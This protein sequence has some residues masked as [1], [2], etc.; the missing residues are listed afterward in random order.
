MA[1]GELEGK[2]AFVSGSGRNIGKAIALELASMGANLVLNVRSNVDEADAVAD[3]VRSRGVEAVTIVGDI[4]AP[5][6]VDEVIGRAGERFG[7]LDILVI[8]AA[9][10]PCQ[11]F[12]DTTEED[13]HRV[14]DVQLH[15]AFRLAKAATPW[16]IE[17]GWGRIIHVTGPD[18]FI[19]LPN[20]AHNVVAKAGLRGLTKSLAIELGRHGITVNDV[21]PGAIDTERSHL[22]H[23][24]ITSGGWDET[25]DGKH[26]IVD[27]IPVGRLGLPE[28]L[29]YACGFLASPRASFVTGTVVCCFGGHW[30][31]A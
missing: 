1:A 29:A 10:R 24:Q 19:G 5:S 26:Q 8:N 4:A 21:A 23:P 6:T 13:W 17:H 3:A 11:S 7:G 20:R 2:T 16:M 28:D 14:L 27:Q 25:P 30:N 9:L 18:A 31:V 22:S 12:V 15:S